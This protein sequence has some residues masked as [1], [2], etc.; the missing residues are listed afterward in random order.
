MTKVFIGGSRRVGRTNALLRKRLDNI[1]ENGFPILIGDANGADRAIQKYLHS[2]HYDNV[3][4]FCS[5]GICRNNLGNWETRSI[6][7]GTRRR[8][9]QFYSAKDRVMAQ[10]ATIGLMMW[11]GKSVG[12]M[13]NLFRLLTQNKKALIYNVPE[14][15]FIEFRNSD[16]WE[17][18]LESQDIGLRY[19]IEQRTK[20]EKIQESGQPRLFVDVASDLQEVMDDGHP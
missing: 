3:R 13:L 14:K 5:G 16:E 4:V 6:A 9:A 12:T 1:M 20:L 17:N 15:Q 11:D 18:F 10:E 7:V 19:K 8:D 2:K